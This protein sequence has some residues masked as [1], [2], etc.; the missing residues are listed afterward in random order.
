MPAFP[1]HLAL[2]I[3]II[4]ISPMYP[5]K[6]YCPHGHCIGLH[7]RGKMGHQDATF[8]V[9]FTAYSSWWYRNL[10]MNV[11]HGF[12]IGDVVSSPPVSEVLATVQ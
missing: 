7:I 12:W 8:E 5:V 1:I 2:C 9:A 6:A 4:G 10:A 3:D 11:V